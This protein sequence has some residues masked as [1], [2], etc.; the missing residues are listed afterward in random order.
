MYSCFGKSVGP[1]ELKYHAYAYVFQALS[2][3]EVQQMNF[4]VVQ[5]P[6]RNKKHSSFAACLFVMPPLFG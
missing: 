3:A 2:S 5:Y 4:V 1:Q 6:G